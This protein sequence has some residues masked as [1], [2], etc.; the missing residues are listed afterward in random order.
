[1]SS[2]ANVVE[3]VEVLHDDADKWPW[4]SKRVDSMLARAQVLIFVKSITVAEE[5]TQSFTD[6]LDKSA[7]FVHGG[8]DP[9][10]RM[11]VVGSFQKR[12]IDV[13]IATDIAAVLLESS[14]TLTV[15]S[16]DAAQD[17]ETHAQ[18]AA[19]ASRIGEVGEAFTLLTHDEHS[20]NMA[21][22][23]VGHFERINH[24][25]EK[26]LRALARMSGTF[27]GTG[28]L[29]QSNEFDSDEDLF[30]PGIAGAFGRGRAKA[31]V[32]AAKL[33]Q[34]VGA[35][36]EQTLSGQMAPTF[37]KQLAWATPQPLGQQPFGVGQQ[38]KAAGPQQTAATSVLLPP[39]LQTPPFQSTLPVSGLLPPPMQQARLPGLVQQQPVGLN[40]M[41]TPPAASS[42]LLVGAVPR[43]PVSAMRASAVVGPLQ[44]QNVP[45]LP[46]PSLATVRSQVGLNLPVQ[47]HTIPSAPA[48]DVAPG[49]SQTEVHTTP[50]APAADA[51]P[52]PSQTV[53]HTTP[54]APAADAAPAPSQTGAPM[55]SSLFGTAPP[56]PP[57]QLPI[58]HAPAPAAFGQGVPSNV[59]SVDAPTPAGTGTQPNPLHAVQTAPATVLGNVALY[60]PMGSA[61]TGGTAASPA[62]APA[63]VLGSVALYPP[64]GSASTG[65]TAAS[66]ADI[67]LAGLLGQS[68]PNMVKQTDAKSEPAEDSGGGMPPIPDMIA[69]SGGSSH[70]ASTPPV[71]FQLGNGVS[72]VTATVTSALPITS[73]CGPPQ[74][75]FSDAVRKRNSPRKSSP[76]RRSRPRSRSRSRSRRLRRRDSRSRSRLSDSRAQSRRHDSRSRGRRRR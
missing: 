65:G 47:M 49:P 48:A 67:A 66:P 35:S 63:T 32:S 38:A 19:L 5:L 12:E 33:V 56:S 44:G 31:K 24:P 42:N 16:Y 73:D 8:L 6:F 72:S 50:S 51:A 13:L 17:I 36:Q 39:V 62:A 1:M 61:S 60:P 23:L 3:F 37:L 2:I 18:R 41:G 25:I 9:A 46:T 7:E 22:L 59:V 52:A 20:K 29:E 75:G 28:F 76:R 70:E 14:N 27:A 71:A 11:R 4:L 15:V 53:V 40:R 64:M 55:P 57:T 54:S 69:V 74:R 45:P 34:P 43:G 10:E 58:L 68:S 21:T 30:A 26:D